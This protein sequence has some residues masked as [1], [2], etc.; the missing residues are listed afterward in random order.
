MS[1]ER[2]GVALFDACVKPRCGVDGFRKFIRRDRKSYKR[3]REKE[4]E[5]TLYTQNTSIRARPRPHWRA[6]RD[7]RERRLRGQRLPPPIVRVR[8]S[9]IPSPHPCSYA[10][11]AQ[12]R[13]F[14]LLHSLL[15]FFLLH[16]S[17]GYMYPDIICIFYYYYRIIVKIALI[18]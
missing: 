8:P 6:A 14:R 5:H 11:T 7:S 12:R 18:V 3:E 16:F 13:S 9:C 17:Y 10:H 4:K 15:S 2:D 1:R